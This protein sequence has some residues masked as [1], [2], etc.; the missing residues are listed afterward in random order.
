[1]V[2]AAI[3]CLIMIN[4]NTINSGSYIR[5]VC[6]DDADPKYNKLQLRTEPPTFIELQP[7]NNI[8]SVKDYPALRYG[9]KQIDDFRLDA[10]F[11][12]CPNEYNCGDVLHVDLSHFDASEMVSMDRMFE[13]MEN[14]ENI[15]FGEAR[16]DNVTSMN[17]A[18]EWTDVE[19]LDLT[20]INFSNVTDA[21]MMTY[22][23]GD[24]TVILA[25]RDLSNVKTAEGIFNGVSKLDLDGALLSDAVIEAMAQDEEFGCEGLKEISMKG[26]NIRMIRAV[27]KSILES[28]SDVLP[29]I[30]VVVDKEVE[31]QILTSIAPTNSW[32]PKYRREWYLAITSG[33]L[34]NKDN[35][36]QELIIKSLRKDNL[37]DE[38]YY[39]ESHCNL[40][41][42]ENKYPWERVYAVGVQFPSILIKTFFDWELG[43]SAA[44]CSESYSFVVGNYY[45]AFSNNPKLKLYV[46]VLHKG[47]YT[48]VDA[49]NALVEAG[50]NDLSTCR[51]IEIQYLNPSSLP[52]ILHHSSK[53][54]PIT[55]GKFNL[56]EEWEN[57]FK[58]VLSNR[59]EKYQSYIDQCLTKLSR[60]KFN[61]G[62]VCTDTDGNKHLIY[63]TKIIKISPYQKDD[64]VFATLSMESN[65]NLTVDLLI[66]TKELTGF[67]AV[68]HSEIMGTKIPSEIHVPNIDLEEVFKSIEEEAAP[69]IEKWK[70]ERDE[71][72]KSSE[73]DEEPPFDPDFMLE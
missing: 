63:P 25:G 23:K 24:R 1:M 57:K 31:N 64:N 62:E 3:H 54:S 20:C 43:I 72:A 46:P 37:I 35:E 5:I 29:R 40:R 42:S 4:L 17:S 50:F 73:A 12:D 10:T 2:G 32:I 39:S 33:E 49:L 66:F 6:S 51:I 11:P 61:H 58:A 45:A 7:G 19:K 26:C 13:R 9:F 53:W 69:I 55:D 71:K 38:I 44:R 22:S 56:T 59:K 28:E 27:L 52:K 21:E 16:I 36:I 60:T 48:I 14:L 34:I 70:K 41:Q 47:F 30:R 68:D 18:F 65:I 15:F 8:L 67:I